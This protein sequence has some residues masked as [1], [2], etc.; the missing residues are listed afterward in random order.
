[1]AATAAF[2]AV[3]DEIPSPLPHP[4]GTQRIHDPSRVVSQARV[5][6]TR[7]H[8]PTPGHNGDVKRPPIPESVMEYFR[9]TGAMGGIARAKKHSKAQLSEWAKLGGRASGKGNQQT[10]KGSK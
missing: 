3:T 10:K 5:E 4:D 2:E 9:K 7:A 1:M 6:L 8:D